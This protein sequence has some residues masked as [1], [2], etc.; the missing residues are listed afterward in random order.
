[1]SDDKNNNKPKDKSLVIMEELIIVMNTALKNLRLYSPEHPSFLEYVN[2]LKMKFNDLFETEKSIEIMVQ[3]DKLLFKE[4]VLSQEN[5]V[6]K[7][8]N[9][10]LYH[11]GIQSV[12]F[13]KGLDN[14]EIISFLKIILI[15]PDEVMASEGLSVFLSDLKSAFI[16]IKEREK[17]EIVSEDV[18]MHQGDSGGDAHLT[19]EELVKRYLEPGA[20]NGEIPRK[21][22]Y[23]M[24]ENPEK[25]SKFLLDVTSKSAEEN[26][27]QADDIN[28]QVDNLGQVIEK[29]AQDVDRKY[30]EEKSYYLQKLKDMI[31]CLPDE[32]KSPLIKK[33]LLD[34]L[35]TS[36]T[37]SQLLVKFSAVELVDIC[38]SEMAEDKMPL[39]DLKGILDK[40]TALNNDKKAEIMDSLGKKQAKKD[41]KLSSFA[42]VLD[43]NRE[44]QDTL[45]LSDLENKLP[46]LSVYT[47]EEIEKIELIATV[48]SKDDMMLST[49]NVL[50]EVLPTI[51][52]INIYLRFVNML[53]DFLEVYV[54]KNRF[55]VALKIL[56]VFKE[57]FNSKREG[58]LECA[59][60][61]DAAIKEAGSE[62]KM[63][64]LVIMMSEA[65]RDSRNFELISTYMGLLG[66]EAVN[67]LLIIL[68]KEE[69]RI[70]RKLIVQ[71]LIYLGQTHIDILAK[72]L[73]DERWYLVRNIVSIFGEIRDEKA[74][75]YIKGI[76]HHPDTRVRG[77]AIRSLGLIGTEKAAA[78]LFSA[79]KDV[80]RGLKQK[81]VRWLG[82]IGTEAA[83]PQLK[84]IL[85]KKDFFNRFYFIKEETIGALEKINSPLAAVVLRETAKKKWF[86]F[87]A[88]AKK[89]RS[90]A[91]Q[92]LQKIEKTNKG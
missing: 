47:K 18:M 28:K 88:R 29:M 65:E 77:E 2:R 55:D 72:R 79:L 84:R 14:E 25:F 33:K 4:E 35:D 23:I 66:E 89:L 31:T 16:E 36:A 52:E 60:K 17:L 15:N 92:S 11:L 24:T 32:V 68:G 85:Q 69:K 75:E 44:D 80:D 20:D 43:R 13:R 27:P 58:G 19:D 1:M 54:S 71:L 21:I 64:N 63:Y 12:A 39:V 8:F 83:I 81:A 10:M 82:E 87:G 91:Q 90:L 53:Q 9:E 76:I 61:L 50:L 7:L 67:V 62:S 22:F 40:I 57:E 26:Q 3:K 5:A 70:I 46:E 48:C 74:I 6:V 37:A 41:G 86:H 51:N 78:L 45:S 73:S 42:A 30:P 56:K 34:Q 38:Q 49:T 59:E